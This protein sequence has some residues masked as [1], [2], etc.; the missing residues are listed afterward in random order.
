MFRSVLLVFGLICAAWAQST[1]FEGV[2]PL[3]T[4]SKYWEVEPY[5]CKVTSLSGEETICKSS[6]QFDSLI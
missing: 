1:A 2:G 3:Y 5:I 4:L 6:E